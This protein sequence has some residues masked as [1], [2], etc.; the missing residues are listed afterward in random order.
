MTYFKN[1]FFLFFISSFVFAQGNID[2]TIT[3]IEVD[4]G[5]IRVM[6]YNSEDSFLKHP[7]KAKRYTPDSESINYSFKNLPEGNYAISI[8][9]D[10]NEDL[11]LNIGYFG[12]KEN[13]GFS[14]LN[15]VDYEDVQFVQAK[16]EINENSSSSQ[17]I[18][19]SK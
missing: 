6:L 10:K 2:L 4:E 17:L 13:F 8:Y 3:N 9:Q 15:N 16:F 11:E 5:D 7:Y 12:A 14:N 18:N 19:L 1:T